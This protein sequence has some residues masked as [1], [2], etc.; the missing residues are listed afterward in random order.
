MIHAETVG[1]GRGVDT[2]MH[3]HT[4]LQRDND[5]F[6]KTSSIQ[7]VAGAADMASKDSRRSRRVPPA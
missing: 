3:R 4:Y 7:L 1:K 6:A 2:T 5:D